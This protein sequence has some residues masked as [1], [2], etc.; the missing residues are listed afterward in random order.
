[1]KRNHEQVVPPSVDRVAGAAAPRL[2]V[3]LRHPRARRARARRAHPRRVRRRLLSRLA[4]AFLLRLQ[5][6]LHRQ[7]HGA[8]LP[9][10]PGR[11]SAHGAPR[12]SALPR[13]RGR[14][15]RGRHRQAGGAGGRHRRGLPHRPL[16]VRGSA[17]RLRGLHRRAG[18]QVP[19]EGAGHAAAER[20]GHAADGRAAGYEHSEHGERVPQECAGGA[21]AQGPG[22]GADR[23]HG[24]DGVVGAA[25]RHALLQ[26]QL[27]PQQR[28]DLRSDAQG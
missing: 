1:M 10:A 26:A 16:P 27:L 2:R 18:L 12:R 22:H 25:Y 23:G 15:S 8:G 4:R 7:P 5:H 28:Q 24:R 21:G 9:P 20:S 6:F 19:R 13:L 17:A 3:Q 11:A 14:R